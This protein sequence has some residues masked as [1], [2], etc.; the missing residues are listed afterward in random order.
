MQT[1]YILLKESLIQVYI[2]CHSTKYFVKQCMKIKQNLGEN[3]H[4]I[5]VYFLGKIFLNVCWTY[6][7]VF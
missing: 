7:T 6:Y 5:S 1:K 2:V 4:E 3:L